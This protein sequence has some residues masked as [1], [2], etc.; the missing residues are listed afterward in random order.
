[1]QKS[2]SIDLINFPP[3]FFSKNSTNGAQDIVSD[4]NVDQKNFNNLFMMIERGR[5]RN[6][7]LLAVIF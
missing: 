4:R 6:K 3:N 7:F 5:T 2:I 1:M